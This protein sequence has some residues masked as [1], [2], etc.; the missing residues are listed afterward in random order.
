MIVREATLDDTRDIV[1]VNL[2]NPDRPFDK[3]VESLSIAERYSHGGPWMSVE[4][5]AV[6]LNNM[7]AWGHVPLVVEEEGRVIAETEFYIG[8]DIPPLGITLDISVLY[9]HADFQRR[10][11]GTLLMQEMI[12]RAERKKCSYITVSRPGAPGFYARFGFSQILN[13][14]V[15]DYNVPQQAD[16]CTCTSYSPADFEDPPEGNLWIGRFL[17]PRQKWQEIVDAMKMRNAILPERAERPRPEGRYSKSEE[18]LSFLV[19]EWGN[20]S[21]ADV[22][23]WSKELTPKIVSEL[24]SHARLAGYNHACL[25]CH[26]KV[27]KLVG[28]ICKSTPRPSWQ[29]WGKKLTG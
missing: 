1:S 10:G 15:V 12:S 20:K 6:H 3:P 25:M 8:Q 9:V 21:R 22:Y 16:V 13:L 7:L 2:T 26:P 24:L 29:V 5:C 11:A 23:C 17:S 14:E 18:F 27:A 19:P 28:E 4:S